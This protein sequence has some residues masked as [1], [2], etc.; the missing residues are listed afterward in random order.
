MASSSENQEGLL[1]IQE[2]ILELASRDARIA[3]LAFTH[4]YRKESQIVQGGGGA[5]EVSDEEQQEEK[6]EDNDEDGGSEM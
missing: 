3:Q 4:L 5:E 6:E 2:Y 1:Y